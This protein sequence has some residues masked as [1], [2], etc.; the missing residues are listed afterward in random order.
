MAKGLSQLTKANDTKE[1]KDNFLSTKGA[2]SSLVSSKRGGSPPIPLDATVELPP[3]PKEAPFGLGLSGIT[4][5]S[6][7]TSVGNIARSVGIGSLGIVEGLANAGEVLTEVPGEAFGAFA[8]GASQIEEFLGLGAVNDPDEVNWRKGVENSAE[9]MTEP[10]RD[11]FAAAGEE[12]NN[13]KRGLSN[14]YTNASLVDENGNFNAKTLGEG[15]D[16]LVKDAATALPSLGIAFGGALMKVP[17]LAMTIIGLSSGGDFSK[18]LIKEGVDP[19]VAIAGGTILGTTEAA[20]EQVG[21]GSLLNQ[22]SKRTMINVAKGA[23]TEGSTEALQTLSGNLLNKA[24][25]P[26][27]Q[28]RLN[29]KYKNH[30]NMG[31]MA[32]EMGAILMQMVSPALTGGVLG[33][34]GSGAVGMRSFTGKRVSEADVEVDRGNHAKL[35]QEHG[36]VL[37]NLNDGVYSYDQ[38][39]NI[40]ASDGKPLGLTAFDLMKPVV[41]EAKVQEIQEGFTDFK[42]ARAKNMLQNRVKSQKNNLSNLLLKKES[43]HQAIES[44]QIEQ[45][46]AAI[47]ELAQIADQVKAL[48][49]SIK[50]D[51][52]VLSGLNKEIEAEIREEELKI[53]QKAEADKVKFE[54]LSKQIRGELQA[55]KTGEVRE[56]SK[57]YLRTVDSLIEKQLTGTLNAQEQQLMDEIVQESTTTQE[58]GSTVAGREATLSEKTKNELQVLRRSEKDLTEIFDQERKELEDRIIALTQKFRDGEIPMHPL[59]RD[60]IN[61][62]KSKKGNGTITVYEDRLFSRIKEN[63]VSKDPDEPIFVG[64]PRTQNLAG[65]LENL[66]PKK[67]EKKLI[68]DGLTL[69]EKHRQAGEKLKRFSELSGKDKADVILDNV[70]RLQREVEAVAGKAGLLG[71]DVNRRLAS[72]QEELVGILNNRISVDPNDLE[73]QAEYNRKELV[74]QELLEAREELLDGQKFLSKYEADQVAEKRSQI[75]EMKKALAEFEEYLQDEPAREADRNDLTKRALKELSPDQHRELFPIAT[76]L[77]EEGIR[78]PTESVLGKGNRRKLGKAEEYDVIPNAWRVSDKNPRSGYVRTPDEFADDIGMSEDEFLAAL[79]RELSVRREMASRDKISKKALRDD[80]E[81]ERIQELRHFPLDVQLDQFLSN[82]IM[83]PEKKMIQAMKDSVDSMDRVFNGKQKPI[84]ELD[85]EFDPQAFDDTGV[86]SVV[87]A[88]NQA[89]IELKDGVPTEETTRKILRGMAD[90]SFSNPTQALR[91]RKVLR[92]TAEEALVRDGHL[93]GK[94]FQGENLPQ[95]YI[96]ANQEI[97]GERESLKEWYEKMVNQTSK[98][99]LDPLQFGKDPDEVYEFLSAD[100]EGIWKGARDSQLPEKEN[101]LTRAKSMISSLGKGFSRTNIDIPEIP[102]FSQFIDRE[103]Q[104]R[105]R[106]DAAY[107]KAHNSLRDILEPLQDPADLNTFERQVFLAD[108]RYMADRGMILSNE[109]D[110]ETLAI[111]EERIKPFLNERVQKALEKRREFMDS[112]RDQLVKTGVFSKKLENEDYFRHQVIEYVTMKA[113]ELSRR[114]VKDPDSSYMKKRKGGKTIM[115]NYL[116]VESRYI[117]GALRD[118]EMKKLLN[119]LEKSKYNKRDEITVDNNGDTI[120]ATV[121][122][123]H[124][125][126]RIDQGKLLYTA[127][128]LTERLNKALIESALIEGSEGP[129]GEGYVQDSL[130]EIQKSIP[131]KV[132]VVPEEIAAFIER[133]QNQTRSEFDVFMNKVTGE[134]KKWTLFGPLNNIKYNI[135]NTV[136]DL[137]A[138]VAGNYKIVGKM[139]DSMAEIFDYYKKG[140]ASQTLRDAIDKGVLDASIS[141]SEFH[142]IQTHADFK[143]LLGDNPDGSKIT[144]GIGKGLNTYKRFINWTANASKARE[145]VMRY[146][147]YLHYLDDIKENGQITNYGASIPKM[148][149]ALPDKSDQ[150]AKVSRELLGDYG[151]VSEYGRVLRRYAVP[152]Y[153]WMEVNL[154]RYNRLIAN[155]VTGKKGGETHAG[156]IAN[157]AALFWVPALIGAWNHLMHPEEAEALSDHPRN[158]MHIILGRDSSGNIMTMRTQGAFTDY[159]GWLGLE[160]LPGTYGK[161]HNQEVTA[162]EIVGDMLKAPL[163][164]VVGGI[165]PAVKF[166]YEQVSGRATWPDPFANRKH[167]KEFGEGLSSMMGLSPEY[168]AIANLFRD[169]TGDPKKA[170]RPYLGERIKKSLIYSTPAGELAYYDVMA[171]KDKW[172]RSKGSFEPGY[173]NTPEAQLMRNIRKSLRLKDRQAFKETVNEYARLFGKKDLRKKLKRSIKNLHPL[174]R[175]SKDDK[176]DF[177]STLS[178]RQKRTLKRAI[179]HYESLGLR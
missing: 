41:G 161:I 94:L 71:G 91:A 108:Q 169:V 123:G 9:M 66:K 16:I 3:R 61:E 40:I 164:K 44:G 88:L 135:N 176:R 149:D 63:L 20:L 172:R 151:N 34:L 130:R 67:V 79:D 145:A 133:T 154:T 92:A 36:D 109:F 144:N 7:S 96:E 136:G 127:D 22:A 5:G 11:L 160:D 13:M 121:P 131:N 24:F 78:V 50:S 64:D 72:V 97:E 102:E 177:V 38:D 155:A 113:N 134:W 75:K 137:D 62:L 27:E 112:L 110:P 56:P 141:A 46:A 132:L 159:L 158:Q 53:Q 23:L 117:A 174:A 69:E 87:S 54:N 101:I 106:M 156:R 153:S 179:K 68:T 6:D 129:L 55:L 103:S 1:K 32:E 73:A 166:G 105:S 138:V 116:D 111:E 43:I 8:E 171:M 2:F 12:L 49:D 168:D 35:Q 152:F 163:K 15:V 60:K 65:D 143:D 82:D 148:V 162:A 125:A 139:R 99:P 104:V 115:T 118:I 47:E 58:D 114:K 21:A 17:G 48:N 95:E 175:M 120:Q 173:S 122:E 165:N 45:D 93:A 10:A 119:W 98:V 70:D 30:T 39:G 52:T 170:T 29:T 42:R 107:E 25:S 178:S 84:V 100:I 74:Y 142:S 140:K 14:K 89:R 76:K 146:A 19:S 80:R 33:G 57:Q 126:I 18:K 77:K 124:V 150:A 167:H 51:D 157:V 31:A 37:Q 128:S 28:R 83:L 26:E 81:A 86:A 90:S 85:N 4:A 59:V 147:A